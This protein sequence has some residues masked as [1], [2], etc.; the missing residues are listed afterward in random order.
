MNILIIEDE[1]LIAARLVREVRAFFG[2]AVQRLVH[3]DDLDELAESVAAGGFDL[4][5]LDLNLYGQDG[6]NLFKLAGA[7]RFQTIIVSAHVERALTGFDF[8]VLDFVA[9]P[10]SQDRL[11]QAFQRYQDSR[12]DN[13][14]RT[15]SLVVKRMGNIALLPIDEIDHIQADG[16][17]SK[18]MMRDGAAHFHDKPL[19]K[20]IAMLPDF[21]VR[22]HRSYAFNM[23]HFK[24]LNVE[25]GGKY[26]VATQFSEAIP[27]SRALYPALKESL[28]SL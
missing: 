8:G 7:A 3:H 5:L 26:S 20:L 16:H 25:A 14:S 12:D 9:K 22:V 21:F 24:R 27:V 11:F 23:R 18:V 13:R 10:F 1:P 2:A 15:G 4:V 28:A 17:Y 6:F 19:D